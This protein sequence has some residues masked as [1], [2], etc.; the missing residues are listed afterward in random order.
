M[1]AQGND[2]I[3]LLGQW[4]MQCAWAGI[5]KQSMP[6][7]A[8]GGGWGGGGKGHCKAGAHLSIVAALPRSPA[9]PPRAAAALEAASSGSEESGRFCGSMRFWRGISANQACSGRDA[10][11]AGA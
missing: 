11:G 3:T 9:A 4:T 1:G 5:R 2:N 8:G 7:C 10:A 6:A